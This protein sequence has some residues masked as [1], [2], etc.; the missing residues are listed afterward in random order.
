MQPEDVIESRL[1]Q[2]M[3]YVLYLGQVSSTHLL[4]TGGHNL[5]SGISSCISKSRN[6][7]A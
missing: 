1:R 3:R 5:S 7:S 2:Q 4:G 6:K